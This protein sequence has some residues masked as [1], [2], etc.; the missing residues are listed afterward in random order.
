MIARRTF[1]ASALL[2]VPGLRALARNVRV[3]QS[4]FIIDA[5]NSAMPTLRIVTYTNGEADATWGD[6]KFPIKMDGE[7]RCYA[8]GP[9]SGI[10]CR[11][12]SPSELDIDYLWW[13]E[14]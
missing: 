5:A 12:V 8:T 6:R 1:L 3:A 11:F 10:C 4:T 9:Q 7:F 2:A 13:Y 14:L